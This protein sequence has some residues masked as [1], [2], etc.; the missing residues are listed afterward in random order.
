MFSISRTHLQDDSQK[1]AKMNQSFLLLKKKLFRS[2]DLIQQYS[3]KIKECESLR[4]DVESCQRDSE[5]FKQ[6]HLTATAKIVKLSMENTKLQ[7]ANKRLESLINEHETHIAGDQRLI[8]QLSCKV[9]DIEDR[10]SEKVMQLEL[11]KSALQGKLKEL[12]QK[13]R[14]ISKA[15]ASDLKK[16][17][18]KVDPK[19]LNKKLLK[20]SPSKSSI[21]TGLKMIDNENQLPESSKSPGISEVST[22]IFPE[23]IPQDLSGPP[24]SQS[25]H[26]D[27]IMEQSA[28]E[29][30]FEE[31]D[32]IIEK[33]MGEIEIYND[34]KDE[35]VKKSLEKFAVNGGDKIIEKSMAEMEA[36]K[37][38]KII[39]KSVREMGINVDISLFPP[40]P[41]TIDRNIMTD[42]FYSFKDNPY[43]L[44]CEKCQQLLD[45][46]PDDVI[47]KAMRLPP[48]VPAPPPSPARPVTTR[49]Y[50]EE[51]QPTYPVILDSLQRRVKLLEKR[52]KRQKKLETSQQLSC[53]NHSQSVSHC[54]HS[55]SL[56]HSSQLDLMTQLLG[57]IMHLPGSRSPEKFLSMRMKRKTHRTKMYLN[58]WDVESQERTVRG[59]KD[60]SSKSRASSSRESFENLRQDCNPEDTFFDSMSSAGV[61]KRK[62]E[63]LRGID[64][65]GE[66]PCNS[67]PQKINRGRRKAAKTTEELKALHPEKYPGQI[68]PDVEM[69]F[70][71]NNSAPSTCQKRRHPESSGSVL[72]DT[73]AKRRKLAD[74]P[75]KTV[76][77]RSNLLKNLKRLKKNNT[78]VKTISG[79]ATIKNTDTTSPTDVLGNKKRIAHVPRQPQVPSITKPS[80]D[81]DEANSENI[82]NN[83][84]EKRIT[85]SLRKSSDD[86]TRKNIEQLNSS[87][88]DTINNDSITSHLTSV[89]RDEIL[90][91]VKNLEMSD[92]ETEMIIDDAAASL[93]PVPPSSPTGESLEIP[94]EVREIPSIYETATVSDSSDSER[95]DNVNSSNF[96]RELRNRQIHVSP[97]KPKSIL[98]H[99]K[100]PLESPASSLET[101]S[102]LAPS[103][104][105]PSQLIPQKL[106]KIEDLLDNYLATTKK[107]PGRKPRVNEVAKGLHSKAEHLIKQ[108]LK[109]LIES[110]DWNDVHLSVSLTLL[111]TKSPRTVAKTLIDFLVERSDVIEP[112]DLTYTP[113]A[114]PMTKS[115]QRI[116]TLLIDLNREMPG[117]TDLVLQGIDFT[118]FRLNA[119]PSWEAVG[120]L[121]KLFTI[122]VR[123]RKDRERVRIM[124]CDAIYGL[125]KKSL[126][127]LHAVLTCWPEVLPMYDAGKNQYLPITI[128]H[129]VRTHSVD[130]N[131]KCE[132]LKKLI[133]GF[134]KYPQNESS[135]V[136][137]KKL[138]DI[139]ASDSNKN[140]ECGI[141]LLSKKEGSEWTNKN[142]IQGGLMRMIVEGNSS[143]VYQLLK[144]L[145]FLMRPF[146]VPDKE[147]TVKRIVEQLKALV[148]S[149][150]GSPDLQ[151]GAISALVSL[152]RHRFDDIAASVLN[153]QP[154]RALPTFLHEQ[155]NAFFAA[156]TTHWSYIKAKNRKYA[157]GP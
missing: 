116:V 19:S 28:K 7:E 44:F 50:S 120:E 9:E 85:R 121:S 142:I 72:D 61:A 78:A 122:L 111:N 93:P 98:S 46:S 151:E 81:I 64:E 104:D 76:S 147:G 42:E 13:M 115:L 30:R 10:H 49:R 11:E 25:S 53:C 17:E 15:H 152:S 41:V 102:S 24:E 100:E 157:G 60:L 35:I 54:G 124:C 26:D 3:N 139:L 128:V 97:T 101:S 88:E 87:Q 34:F 145:G 62:K 45:K 21:I 143:E 84:G 149:D 91:A 36:D 109:R 63:I 6:Q 135:A 133:K 70:F 71:E 55:N 39:Q 65:S 23:D 96:I 16:L 33:S 66:N 58:D 27:T 32:E 37:P 137:G 4:S 146:P 82:F 90:P 105:P 51:G 18:K 132:Q 141:L 12:E 56:S 29:I 113:P 127:V 79:V 140:V 125:Q 94:S 136:L 108:E 67:S 69:N 154:I 68:S 148:A 83:L 89:F 77:V 8:Q 138:L 150:A 130:D 112:L 20:V 117:L 103:L 43:P 14:R 126:I 123:I 99:P 119:S 38:E 156:R 110:P 52:I 80:T 118:L 129:I 95:P 134:F 155:M 144:L 74:D 48:H 5:R 57:R 31:D 131:A 1:A 107:R 114:P 2:H 153:W 47:C 86:K 22:E 59:V 92:E 106:K 73:V 40:K 75:P